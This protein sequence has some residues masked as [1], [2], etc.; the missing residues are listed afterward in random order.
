MIQPAPI[1]DQ[2]PSVPAAEIVARPDNWYRGKRLLLAV[3]M[4]VFGGWFAYDGWV[5]WP[6][7]NEEARSRGDLRPVHSDLDLMIQKTLAIALPPLGLL[8][9]ARIL[10]T[11]RGTYRLRDGQLSIPG[12]PEMPIEAITQINLERWDRKGIA[13]VDYSHA[14]QTGRFKLDD[15][16]YERK[17]T[18]EI[19]DQIKA[20][21]APEDSA[22]EAAPASTEA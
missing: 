6:R 10:Y 1:E 12:H 4:I 20:R 2:N 19:L 17:P 13:V 11:S 14:G 16:I 8:W 21:I 22:V 15:F 9:I 7:E 5:K 18:D 3:G